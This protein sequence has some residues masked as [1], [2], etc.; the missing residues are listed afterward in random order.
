MN[1]IFKTR[2][3]GFAI[4]EAL[5]AF[6][7]LGIGVAALVYLQ[8]NLMSGSGTSKARAE[9]MELA[10]FRMEI[11]RNYV[12][13]AEFQDSLYSAVQ[14][15]PDTIPGVN[16]EY[17]VSYELNGTDI[18]S[19]TP[20]ADAQLSTADPQRITVRVD[21]PNSE[22]GSEE[23][24]LETMLYFIK[25]EISSAI[26]AQNNGDASKVLLTSPWITGVEGEDP[27][28]APIKLADGN[29]DDNDIATTDDGLLGIEINR[30]IATTGTLE[31]RS[32][33]EVIVGDEVVLTS[34]G[35][36]VHR[37]QGDIIIDSGAN[38]TLGDL[39][40]D[41]KILASPPSY[42]VFP[43]N[44]HDDDG[45]GV[46]DVASYVCYVPGD[47]TYGSS[48]EAK[49]DPE[50]IC[51]DN[52]ISPIDDD[53]NDLN[54]GWYGR[55]GNFGIAI[56][57]DDMV[58]TT[59]A[60]KTNLTPSREYVT[61]RCKVALV[62]DECPDDDSDVSNGNG[63]IIA[64]EGINTPYSAQTFLIIRN[65]T[66]CADYG[67]TFVDEQIKR[68]L[69]GEKVFEN[70]VPKVTDP[71]WDKNVVLPENECVTGLSCPP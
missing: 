19:S 52:F 20:I 29:S 46:D 31:G 44:P 22:G 41:L 14:K 5:I 2:Q 18:A 35:G 37:L 17:T 21:W 6:L 70:G 16:A 38:T 53:F 24:S 56:H 30:Y 25:P 39:A 3:S 45:D 54:G 8:G 50:T 40:T 28:T 69:Y 1:L 34:F 51:P 47:C 62:S 9:A 64:N 7:L 12:E 36:I 32:N 60:T 59:Y 33:V 49:T 23:V 58:C 63:N 26:N 71:P 48:E 67:V 68:E 42:C 13:E 15:E 55:I 11:L 27:S 10:Q 65:N 43:I 61:Y 57:P 4:I 66:D